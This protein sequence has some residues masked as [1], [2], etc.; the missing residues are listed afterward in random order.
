MNWLRMKIQLNSDKKPNKFSLFYTQRFLRIV[1]DWN[2]LDLILRKVWACVRTCVSFCINKNEC[3]SKKHIRLIFE[4][5]L[6][7][8]CNTFVE[9]TQE[10]LETFVRR[11]LSIS[12]SYTN[13]QDLY[14]LADIESRRSFTKIVCFFRWEPLVRSCSFMQSSC[15]TFFMYNLKDEITQ[16]ITH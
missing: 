1:K 7:F 3:W 11:E 10:L 13:L 4:E 6:L 12:S 5:L 14:F 9:R 16:E 2:F 8:Y 15:F